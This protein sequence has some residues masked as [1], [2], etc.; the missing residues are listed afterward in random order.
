MS[1]SEYINR[2]R[3]DFAAQLMDENSKMPANELALRSGFSSVAS[4]YRNFKLYK[5]CPP[6]NYMKGQTTQ[7]ETQE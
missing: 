5:G 3:V 7:D 1:F 6:L 2:L 4:F